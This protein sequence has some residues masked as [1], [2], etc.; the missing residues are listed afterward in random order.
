MHEL[1]R[2]LGHE[3]NEAQ[4]GIL[5]RATLHKLRDSLTIPQSFSVLAQ[6]PMFLKAMY[7]EQWKYL[8]NPIRVKSLEEFAQHVEEEQWKFGER[9]FNWSEATIDLV[10]TIFNTL[11]KYLS[12]GQ[13][14][15]M[16]SELPKEL[17]T[18][19]PEVV[20]VQME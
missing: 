4:V 8:E 20:K 15:D 17:K 3:K 1:A 9:Q 6:L 13:V 18:L 16:I 5:L 12:P 14:E 10:K 7:V 19:F 2:N 11:H